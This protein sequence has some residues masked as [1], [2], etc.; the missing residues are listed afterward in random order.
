MSVQPHIVHFNTNRGWGGGEYQI[1]NLVFGILAHGWKCSLCLPPGTPLAE[2]AAA[3]GCGILPLENGIKPGDL[4][5]TMRGLDVRLLHAHDSVGVGLGGRLAHRLGIPLVYT[6]RIA[7]P[8]RR[9]PFSRIKYGPRRIARVIA[10]SETVRRAFLASSRYPANRV[11]VVPSGVALERFRAVSPDFTLRDMA[12]GGFLAGGIGKLSIK[13]NWPF[14]LRVAA[15]LRNVADRPLR[16][17]IAGEGPERTMLER[18]IAKLGLQEQV[19]LL[20]FRSDGD[21]VLKSL[22][23]LF[24][25]SIAEGAGVTV[26]E[27]M[28][29]GVPVVAVNSAGVAETLGDCGLLVEDGDVAAAAGAVKTLLTD[30]ETRGRKIA[31]ARRR[32]RDRYDVRLTVADNLAVYK[33]L[34]L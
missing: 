16:W 8:L 10:I 34:L 9:N 25:P 11:R 20:G 4:L 5:E 7:S 29:L 12:Q 32:V 21:R 23:L 30:R 14:L 17:V 33:E 31:K 1:L 13:K 22:D 27:S 15:S 19:V 18:E 28:A 26:L 24:F 6:R 3:A 2:R